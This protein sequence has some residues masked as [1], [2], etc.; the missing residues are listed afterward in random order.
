[1]HRATH[2][3]LTILAATLL[4]LGCCASAQAQEL[5]LSPRCGDPQTRELLREE[6]ALRPV[7]TR[8]WSLAWMR[9]EGQCRLEISDYSPALWLPLPSQATPE[10]IRA[11]VVRAAWFMS[12][13]DPRPAPQE[14]EPSA[15]QPAQEEP[16]P[17]QALAPPDQGLAMRIQLGV[18]HIPRETTANANFLD[19]WIWMNYAG[20]LS[21]GLGLQTQ[22]ATLVARLPRGDQEEIA[23]LDYLA[24]RAG[25]AWSPQLNPTWRLRLRGDMGLGILHYGM[26]ENK[27]KSEPEDNVRIEAALGMGVLYRWS[28]DIH[29]EGGLTWRQSMLRLG[30][31]A[32]PDKEALLYGLGLTLSLLWTL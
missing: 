12:T 17:P 32:V 5:S 27:E 10:E 31:G 9:A 14:Q 26:L 8:G 28:Q 4:A 15:A 19:G 20:H 3:P 22:T 13:H 25:L 23:R 11:A 1:M 16:P 2:S 29:L 21:A 7:E 24:L 18:Q 6:L 30:D